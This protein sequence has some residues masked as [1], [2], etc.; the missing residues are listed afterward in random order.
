MIENIDILG[1]KARNRDEEIKEKQKQ[2]GAD[3][4]TV[5]NVC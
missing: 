2:R 3:R 5:H 1:L 4:D